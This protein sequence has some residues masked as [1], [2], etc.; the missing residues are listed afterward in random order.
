MPERKIAA[1]HKE[2]GHGWGYKC[3]DCPWL[4]SVTLYSGRRYYKCAA[5][6]E[7]SAEST[8]WAKKWEA[9]GLIDKVLP[10]VSLLKRLKHAARPARLTDEPIKGQIDMFGGE[11]HNENA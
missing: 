11:I 9:C 8:D 2:Y 5:Y 7:S 6:G 4:Y 10:D 3:G 1:M